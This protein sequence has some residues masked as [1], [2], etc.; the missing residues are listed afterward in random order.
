MGTTD[1]GTWKLIPGTKCMVSSLGWVKNRSNGGKPHKG[2]LTSANRMSAMVG[3]KQQLVHR[4]VAMLFLPSPLDQSFTVDHIDRNP[5]NNSVE[6]LRWASSSEQNTNKDKRSVRRCSPRVE[7]TDSVGNKTVYE[8]SMEAATAIQSS[9]VNVCQAIRTGCRVA[10]YYARQIEPEPQVI[11]DEEWKLCPFDSTLR[12]SSLGRIQRKHKRGEGWGFRI[13]P[14]PTK[15]QQG[16]VHA[17]TKESK[18]VPIHRIVMLTFVGASDDPLK[19][20]IDHINRIRSDNR[21]CNLRWASSTEQNTNQT[22]KR[23]RGG[24]ARTVMVAGF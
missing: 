15:D 22:R 4:L 13:T 5:Q 20:T 1:Y 2:S 12:V 8:N 24:V 7:L 17:N 11:D 19:T 18:R 9:Y 21:L 10:G 16:Y 6:N 3:G 14:K 23:M